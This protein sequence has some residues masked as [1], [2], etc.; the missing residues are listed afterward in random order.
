[1]RS[2]GAN[3]HYKNK[4]VKCVK[5]IFTTWHKIECYEKIAKMPS[6][7]YKNFVYNKTNKREREK[8]RH[9]MSGVW[10]EWDMANKTKKT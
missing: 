8:D 10:R 1:M 4:Q 9:I 3:K 2:L 6:R 7:N 5:Q